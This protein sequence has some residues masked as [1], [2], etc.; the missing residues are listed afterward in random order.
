MKK[1]LVAVGVVGI[2]L[3]VFWLAR[4]DQQPYQVETISIDDEQKYEGDGRRFAHGLTFIERPDGNMDAFWSQT[5]DDGQSSEWTHNVMTGVVRH[6][7]LSL[8]ERKP[9]LEAPFAQEPVSVSATQSGTRMI[10]FEDANQTTQEVAQRFMMMDANGKIIK[11]YPQTVKDGAHSGHV[12]S[13][14]DAHVIV[15]SDDWINRGGVDNLGTGKTVN[16]TA[17]DDA[18]NVIDTEAITT[19]DKDREWWPI[20]A[21]SP[22]RALVVWQRYI[23]E[24]DYSQVM[25]ALYDPVAKRFQKR[26]LL[27]QPNNAYYEYQVDYLPAIDAFVVTGN[28]RDGAGYMYLINETGRIV[29]GSF[30][31]PQFVR[32]ASPAIKNKDGSAELT[33]PTAPTGFVKY[34][35]TKDTITEKLQI[36]DDYQ[37]QPMGTA[38]F[39][40]KTDEIYFASLARNGI[41]EKIIHKR[42]EE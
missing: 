18:G 37:W 14:K 41:V 17:Y 2:L 25:Y 31:L 6:D 27:L 12:A 8:K 9:L 3:I 16:L 24:E 29:H 1:V 20:V 15:W 42:G 5:T 19:R 35:V 22:K 11:P 36:H 39:Y 28:T 33:Y 30:N 40:T 21:A 23:D 38:G 10:T 13:T 32:E 7:D 26:P 4:Q 34:E